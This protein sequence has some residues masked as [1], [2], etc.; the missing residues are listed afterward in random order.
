[1]WTLV[2]GLVVILLVVRLPNDRRRDTTVPVPPLQTVAPLTRRFYKAMAVITLFSLG[3][4]SDAFILLRLSDLGVAAVW[5]PLLWSALH[6]V[7]MTSSVIGGALSDRFGRRSMIVLGYLWYAGIYAAFAWFSTLP[8][9]IVT[10]LAYG[11]YFGLTEGVE[12][13]WVADMAPSGARGTAFGIYNAALGIGGLAASVLFGAIW[14]RVSPAAAFF[15]GAS[16]ALAASLLLFLAFSETVKSTGGSLVPPEGGRN[17]PRSGLLY[18]AFPMPRILVTNDDGVHSEGIHALAAALRPLGEVLVVAPHI[19]ASAIGHALT[20]RRP[21]RMEQLREGVY[22]V[23]GTPTD[24]VNVGI[25]TLYKGSRPDLIV[26]GINKGYNLGDDVTYS[27]TVSGALEGALLGVLS[28]AVSQARSPGAYDFGHAAAAAAT[29]AGLALRGAFAPPTFLSL[30][31]PAGKPKGFKLT[32]QAKRNHVTIVDERCDPRGKAYYWIE[33]GEND[34]EPHDRSDF[35]AVRDG[36]VSVTPLQPDMTDHDAL[37]KLE[38]L[39]LETTPCD[40]PA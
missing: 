22:E 38:T 4:A 13:A 17:R 40:S 20:L 8:A 12:K 23:D 31:V 14:T 2:P 15:T 9:A 28:I 21:L 24:C 5:I 7:K 6:V 1:M 34:W 26:S 39:A 19:E 11:L 25:T 3:N 16:L 32:V 29:I 27:G 30:N 37:A 35:Q 33:E 18:L 36:Y 10:F